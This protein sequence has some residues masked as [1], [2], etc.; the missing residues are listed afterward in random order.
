[1]ARSPRERGPRPDQVSRR[2]GGLCA[3]QGTVWAGIRNMYFFHVSKEYRENIRRRSSN[4]LKSQNLSCFPLYMG[5]GPSLDAGKFFSTVSSLLLLPIALHAAV[6]K[7]C[8]LSFFKIFQIR[9]AVLLAQFKLLLFITHI[10]VILTLN[11]AA[12]LIFQT[13]QI[14]L[15]LI[16]LLLEVPPKLPI[17]FRTRFHIMTYKVC[18][19]LAHTQFHF[20]Q[21]PN[22]AQTTCVC[23]CGHTCI[24]TQPLLC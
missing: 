5:P 8:P 13:R 20:R 16:G 22:L 17:A 4:G 6:Y 3:S 23:V 7:S 21:A 11:A 10:D 15:N 9:S 12:R 1:M 2:Q 14:K 18:Y 24:H 19:D